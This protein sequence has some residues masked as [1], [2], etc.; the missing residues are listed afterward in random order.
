M[1]TDMFFSP[2]SFGK[3]YALAGDDSDESRNSTWSYE[4]YVIRKFVFQWPAELGESRGSRC[5]FRFESIEVEARRL[6][7]WRSLWG[8]PYRRKYNGIN[9]SSRASRERDTPGFAVSKRASFEWKQSYK[10][11][12]SKTWRWQNH[13]CLAVGLRKT[14]RNT[15][16]DE[17]LEYN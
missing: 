8:V 12:T 9:R 15:R 10:N 11:L 7:S 6:A 2:V 13:P 16:F 3:Q 5:F 1:F 17:L 4:F 14:H